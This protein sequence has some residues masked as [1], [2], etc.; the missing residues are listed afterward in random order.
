LLQDKAEIH[1]Y[2]PKVTKEQILHDLKYLAQ[3]QSSTYGDWYQANPVIASVAKQSDET[4]NQS[5]N[6]S[7]LQSVHVHTEP[8]TAMANAHAIAIL[9]EWE[10]FKT[11]NWQEV[12]QYMLKPAFVFD[13][14]NILGKLKLQKIGFKLYSIGK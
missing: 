13:G 5:L 12:Y 3:S 14:R 8:Y 11:Y 9:T 6:P 2:D 7:I 4:S 1:I 10:E